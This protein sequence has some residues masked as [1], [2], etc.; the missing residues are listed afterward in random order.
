[1]TTFIA[2]LLIVAIGFVGYAIYQGKVNNKE[3]QATPEPPVDPTPDITKADVG[4]MV[5]L[6]GGNPETFE[7]VNLNIDR[8]DRYEWG[9][10][11]W[12]EISGKYNGRRFFVEV[13]EDDDVE[14]FV[15]RGINVSLE[16]IGITEDDLE[17]M[18]NDRDGSNFV[19]YEGE[20]FYYDGSHAVN[21]FKR[22]K[23][24]GEEFYTWD[25]RTKDGRKTLG[26][27]AWTDEP[28]EGGLMEMVDPE[29]VKVYRS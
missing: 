26:F 29:R 1:M 22:G 4:D 14:L 8:R 10:E 20:K 23:G 5:I 15:G 16:D 24:Q 11:I 9:Q 13:T 18:D 19:E 27:E 6:V 7:D 12:H 17:R 21:F 25:F 28:P 2:I 3:A